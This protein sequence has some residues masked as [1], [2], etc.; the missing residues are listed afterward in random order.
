VEFCNEIILKEYN[1]KD[2]ILLC[3]LKT[4]LNGVS[5]IDKEEVP[6]EA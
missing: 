3:I 1:I 5:V 6:L 4:E 2:M